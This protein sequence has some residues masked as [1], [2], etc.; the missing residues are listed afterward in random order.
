MK[1]LQRLRNLGLPLLLAPI[2]CGS[3]DDDPASNRGEAGPVYVFM[4]QIYTADDR[5][6]YLKLTESLDLEEESLSIEDAQEFPSVANFE[7]IDGKLYVSSGE[8]KTITDYEVTPSLDLVEGV[9]LDFSDYPLDDN[10]N[11]HYQFI[12]GEEKVVLPFEVT[13]RL[14]WDPQEMRITG[15]LED[16]AIPFEEDGLRVGSDGN[17]SATR[18]DK[19]PMMTPFYTYD[20]RDLT[21]DFS[22]IATYDDRLRESNVVTVP[23]PGLERVTRAEDGTT[24]FSSQWTSPFRHLFGDAPAPCV[25]RVAPDGTV[26]EAWTTDFTD[27]TGGRFVMNF[28]YLRGG[29]AIGNVVYHEEFGVDFTGEYDSVIEDQLWEGGYVRAWLFDLERDTAREIE[30][31]DVPLTAVLQSEVVDDRIFVLAVYDDVRTEVYEISDAAV[32]TL[33]YEVPGDVYK[34]ERLR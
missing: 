28:R 17:R 29:K 8:S 34:L 10:A 13:S 4:T 6:V 7:A 14:V 3:S 16:T 26:D 1:T 30:G 19:G 25:V 22:Y 18:F 9:T 2:G 12:V 21:G 11:F 32:A 24:Y 20:E 15:T 27:Q 5:T 23:C 33:K 31:I